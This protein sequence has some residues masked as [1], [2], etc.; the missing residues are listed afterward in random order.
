MPQEAKNF[1][2][3]RAGCPCHKKPNMFCRD[4]QD[5]HATR[6][7][8]CFVGW[9][10]GRMPMPQEAKHVLSGGRRAGCPC[11]KKPNMFCRVGEG[12]DAHATRSQTCFVGWATGRM[13]M[14]QEAKNVFWGGR[15]CLPF[16]LVQDLTPGR[17]VICRGTLHERIISFP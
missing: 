17:R 12:Q 4:G 3:R 9:A 8:K 11:H 14:P 1:W 2:S 13:P 10:T 16:L 7:Q 5:A 6:S 15:R